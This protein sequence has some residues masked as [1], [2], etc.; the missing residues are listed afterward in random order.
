MLFSRVF[1]ILVLSSFLLY[2]CSGN[3]TRGTSSVMS[4]NAR[5]VPPDLRE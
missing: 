4:D 3:V 1:I 2:G 5:L